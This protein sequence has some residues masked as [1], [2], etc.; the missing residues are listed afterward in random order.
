MSLLEVQADK[1]MFLCH[2]FTWIHDVAV[3]IEIGEKLVSCVIFVNLSLGI[4]DIR[5]NNLH[6][7]G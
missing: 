7:P 3:V 6:L 2:Y 5:L 4:F 1:D